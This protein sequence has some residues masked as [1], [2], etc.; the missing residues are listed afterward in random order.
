MPLTAEERDRLT[1]FCKKPLMAILATVYRRGAPQAVPVW[2]DF[3][4]EH[5]IV[6]SVKSRVKVANVLRDNRVTLCVVDTSYHSRGIIV[7][8]TVEVVEAG[9]Q[10]ATR[11]LAVRYLG[12]EEGRKR[13]DDMAKQKRVMI[14][15]TPERL[16]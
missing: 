3:D 8:G 4:G 7:R 5:F 12:E 6:T 11:R 13:A 1:E 15:I 2:Y 16:L 9:A 14:T 10:D